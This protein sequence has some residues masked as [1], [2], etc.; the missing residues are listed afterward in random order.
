VWGGLGVFWVWTSEEWYWTPLKK[1]L[2]RLAGVFL[3]MRA[4]RPQTRALG[5][6]CRAGG[7]GGLGAAHAMAAGCPG[8]QRRGL[9]WDQAEGEASSSPGAALTCWSL[10]SANAPEARLTFLPKQP[11]DYLR[12]FWFGNKLRVPFA[13]DVTRCFPF[14][15]SKPLALSSII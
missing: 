9:P 6:R 13:A 5:A 1:G 14:Y 4:T 11:D 8:Q 12:H 3:K 7:A 10:L 15:N 2:L